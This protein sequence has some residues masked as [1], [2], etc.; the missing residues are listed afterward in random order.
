MINIIALTRFAFLTLGIV[1]LK[2]MIQANS[3]YQVSRYL[4]P[5]NSIALCFCDPN[6]LDCFCISLF[7]HQQSAT[8]THALHMGSALSSRDRL[9]Q[10]GRAQRERILS[11]FALSGANSAFAVN[12]LQ[13]IGFSAESTAMGGAGHVAIA[14]TS[15]INTNPR[16]TVVNPRN[17][18]RCLSGTSAGTSSPF[19]C[20]WEQ[21]FRWPT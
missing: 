10:L 3:D 18:A 17:T 8:Y 1:F 7:A 6:R 2:I 11:I 4:Q 19:G 13:L 20:F 12:G 5:L 16:C 9:R 14:D 21:K 15:S